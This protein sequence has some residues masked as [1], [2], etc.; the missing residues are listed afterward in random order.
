MKKQ[1]R[2]EGIAQGQKTKMEL[3]FQWHFYKG[4]KTFYKFFT[5][6]CTILKGAEFKKGKFWVFVLFSNLP[7]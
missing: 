3:R 2:D 6:A 1:Q 5:V 4:N 7:P